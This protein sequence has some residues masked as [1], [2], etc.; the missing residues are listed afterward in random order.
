MNI[1]QLVP[2]IFALLS[3]SSVEARGQAKQQYQPASYNTTQKISRQNFE[4]F[5][6]AN[7]HLNNQIPAAPSN[8]LRVITYNVHYFTDLH[9]ALSNVQNVLNDV[10]VMNGDVMLFQEVL[11]DTNNGDRKAFD[12]G[13]DAQGYKWRYFAHGPGA[14]LGNMIASKYPLSKTKTF[15]LGYTR[16]MVEAAVPIANGDEITVFATHWEN[17]SQAARNQQSKATV[18]YFNKKGGANMGKFIL[19]ADFNA[20]Y[21]SP[22]IQGLLATNYMNI[23]FNQLHWHMPDYTCW[24]GHPIDFL[25]AGNDVRNNVIGT[26][27]YHTLSSDHLPVI[28]D[29]DL[30]P[31]KGT[32]AP[33]SGTQNGTSNTSGNK[34]GNDGSSGNTSGSGKNKGKPETSEQSTQST[35]TVWG[36]SGS[37]N[38]ACSESFNKVAIIACAAALFAL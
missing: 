37:P 2:A 3:F 15:D 24:A 27:V 8:G 1:T 22:A 33:P 10:R 25:F 6:K 23:S 36:P 9:A 21:K 19:G 31:V 16:V 20:H 13:L 30:Q 28:I 26:Y 18:D 35:G 14:F 7:L 32:L 29:L 4:T 17:G 5:E 12:A 38:S 34:G 11:T